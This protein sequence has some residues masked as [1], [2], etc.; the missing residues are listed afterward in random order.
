MPVPW[1]WW[2]WAHRTGKRKEATQTSGVNIFTR[3]DDPELLNF[4]KI[5]R[6]VATPFQDHFFIDMVPKILLMW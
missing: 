6:T 5:E 2:G 4:S 3:L 1:E